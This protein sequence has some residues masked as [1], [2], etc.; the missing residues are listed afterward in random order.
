LTLVNCLSKIFSP[1][2]IIL[3]ETSMDIHDKTIKRLAGKSLKEL[4]DF[5]YNT[6]FD[7]F[8]PFWEKGGLDK[9]FGGVIC[10]LN[11][12]GNVENNEKT[13][14]F[15]GRG[16]WLYS[17]LFNFFGGDR[18]LE[19]AKNIHKFMLNHMYAG[20][21]RWYDKVTRQG[22]PA[23]GVG[24]DVFGWLFAA[25]GLI[26]YYK[27]LGNDEDLK[28]AKESILAGLAK[29]DMANYAGVEIE[30]GSGMNINN[31]SLRSQGHS[32]VIVWMLAEL[33][34]FVQDDEMKK[35]QTQHVDYL[36]N[37][38]WNEE[39][40]ISNEYLRHDYSNSPDTRWYMFTGH[41]IEVMWML[42]H[43]AVRKKDE[44]LFD[45]IS[46]RL[47]TLLDKSWDEEYDGIGSEHYFAIDREGYPRGQNY[48]MKTMW[49]HT[50]ILI[51]CL[52]VLEYTGAD[53]A[54]DYY[55]KTFEFILRTMPKPQ[56]GVWRQ[57]VD[58]QGNDLKR[59]EFSIYRKGNFHQPRFLML[60]LLSLDRLIKNNGKLTAFE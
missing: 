32:M 26:Q 53:W 24:I 36:V 55:D 6:L 1:V 7:D 35:I 14:I 15:Q 27:A 46:D 23:S 54:A 4:Y 13:I 29:Y 60:N 16:L 22:K 8:L 9:K 20:K 11:E 50:E 5:C 51:G 39:Y 49:A 30:N 38:F 10:E 59:P 52:T 48:D 42:L 2:V 25:A 28:L 43:E 18:W 56:H 17:Y 47:K 37:S 19:N 58:R 34:S 21:G 57:A 40:D 33:L 41:S 31:L 44:Q 45:K 3:K 12:D